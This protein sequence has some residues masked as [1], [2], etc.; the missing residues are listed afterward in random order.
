MYCMPGNY[1]TVREPGGGD[2][3]GM[4]VQVFFKTVPQSRIIFYFIKNDSLLWFPE[5]FLPYMSTV[6]DFFIGYS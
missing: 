3:T 4:N 2:I 6:Y 1:R 5:D